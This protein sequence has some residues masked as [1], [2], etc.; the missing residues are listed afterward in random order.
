M[1][2]CYWSGYIGHSEKIAVGEMV[3]ERWLN[4]LMIESI[5]FLDS[6]DVQWHSV[7]SAIRF[8]KIDLYLI[9]I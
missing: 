7:S 6:E 4:S 3:Q 5:P 2:F 9:G 8:I 1:K